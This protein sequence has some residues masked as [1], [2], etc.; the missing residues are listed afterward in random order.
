MRPVPIQPSLSFSVGV[1]NRKFLCGIKRNDL[2]AAWCEYD[3]FLD[4]R[5]RHAVAGG[6]V[7]F[8]REH[9]SG[10]ELDRLAQRVQPRDQR[11][12]MQPEA[13]AMAEVEAERVHLAAKA[14]FLR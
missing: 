7:G 14:G 5:S 13:Q 10:L 8:H 9:H 3:L 12:L 2:G 6:T 4:A 1:G 11:P